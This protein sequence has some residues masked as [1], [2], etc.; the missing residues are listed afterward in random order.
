MKRIGRLT[1][2]VKEKGKNCVASVMGEWKAGTLKSGGS[3]ETVTSRDQAIAI[4]LSMCGGGKYEEK[5][6]ETMYNERAKKL[7]LALKGELSQN[8]CNKRINSYSS[9][10]CKECSN[11]RTVPTGYISAEFGENDLLNMTI[12]RLQ[13]IQG[14]V[15]EIL[16]AIQY[17]KSRA[18]LTGQSVEM[19]PWMVD[20]VTLAADYMA[21]VAD[22]SVHGDGI[23]LVN[24]NY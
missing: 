7:L 19:E 1:M 18:A 24:P 23:E 22:N 20:K 15:S 21:A 6:S 9:C 16:H 11:S 12:N 4:A 10:N 5:P 13:V 3:G 2:P 8:Q 17:A 14:N